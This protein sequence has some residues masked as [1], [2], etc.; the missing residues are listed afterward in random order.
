M[1][2]KKNQEKNYRHYFKYVTIKK[3]KWTI[4]FL[5]FFVLDFDMATIKVLVL[6]CLV[7]PS[8]AKIN[9]DIL[10]GELNRVMEDIGYKELQVNKT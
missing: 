8:L 5:F 6:A 1:P 4:L 3:N 10:A 7:S 2:Q 9:A